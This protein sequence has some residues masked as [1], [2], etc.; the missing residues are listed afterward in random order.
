MKPNLYR[1]TLLLLG[2]LAAGYGQAQ[3]IAV[4]DSVTVS[5]NAE[6]KRQAQNRLMEFNEVLNTYNGEER[7]EPE[8]QEMIAKQVNQNLRFRL[9]YDANVIVEDDLVPERPITQIVDKKI[10]NYL[11]DFSLFYTKS[12]VPTVEFFNFN[13][14]NLKKR[15]NNYIKVF[16]TQA[17][18]GKNTQSGG[19]Y[20]PVT[21]VAE[22]RVEPVGKK[23]VLWIQRLAFVAPGDSAG[24]TLNDVAL[25]APPPP[26]DSASLR[27]RRQEEALEEAQREQEREEMR[28]T[29]QAYNDFLAKGDKAMIAQDYEAALEAY[30]EAGRINPTNSDVPL[31]KRARVEKAMMGG[32]FGEKE[33]MRDFRNKGE[34]ALKRRNYPEALAYFQKILDSH[35]DSTALA[36]LVSTLNRKL[37]TKTEYDELFTAGQYEKLIKE[38]DTRLKTEKTDTDW[39]LG[40][41]KCYAKLNRDDLALSDLNRA[42]DLDFANLDALLARAGLYR[43]L[44]NLPKAIADLSGYLLIDSENDAVLAQRAQLR[45]RTGN[46]AAAEEDFSKAIKANPRQ[47]THHLERGLLR[48]RTRQ[49]ETALADFSKAIE[50]A[51]TQPDAYF[52]RGMVYVDEKRYAEAGPDFAKVLKGNPAPGYVTRMDSVRK[53]M[54]AEGQEA[55]R[56]GQV[57]AGIDR[58]TKAIAVSSNYTEALND[59]GRAYA[60]LKEY[61]Q[62]VADFT[63]SL[64]HDPNN[65]RTYDLRAEIFGILR[66]YPRAVDDYRRSFALNSNHLRAKLGEA[67]ALLN[68]RKF[69]DAL[70]PLRYLKTE[71]KRLRKEYPAAV[72]RDAFHALGRCEVGLRQYE[73]AV[74]DFGTALDFDE[75]FGAGYFDRGAAYEALQRYDRAAD[76]Y[77]RAIARYPDLPTFHLALGG[78]LEKKADFTGAVAAY[79]DVLRTDS[80]RRVKAPALLHRGT[81]F[82]KLGRYAEALADF[83][84]PALQ[85][86]STHYGPDGW[87]TTGLT[88][89]HA[90]QADAG[91]PYLTRCLAVP[92]YAAQ[93]SYATACAHLLKGNEPEAL[94][95][96]ERAFRGKEISLAYVK[97]DRLLGSVNKD[98]RQKNKPFAELLEKYLN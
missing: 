31:Y 79:G 56:S 88:Y 13:V 61:P 89:L 6:I 84:Q 91:L 41:G 94:T 39:Y 21:R 81:C 5:D 64:R 82:Y 57:K 20:R 19:T 92:A 9:F 8:R 74:E 7:T 93:A 27:A 58:F 51:P 11:I 43:K 23:W 63:T 60:S 90:G 40:R 4:R 78:V 25:V 54:Y 69:N 47:S 85:A 98:F 42:I 1:Y 48:Y 86:D 17:F 38:Y 77:Q 75:N 70:A 96:F 49:R 15:S 45:S 22:L 29:R 66:E 2:W 32:Q 73:E 30:A 52:W 95:W 3:G 37:A 65:W 83:Q 50:L 97:N 24:V 46:L 33:R 35:P 71:Q 53:S 12:D 36:G 62:A 76:D 10:E 26:I 55:I 28:K 44:G 16:Y 72:C 67:S 34:V 59:R 18:K 87:L 68:L 80:A 14:S